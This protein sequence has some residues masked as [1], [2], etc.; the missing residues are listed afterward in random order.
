MRDRFRSRTR[1]RDRFRSQTRWNRLLTRGQPCRHGTALLGLRKHRDELRFFHKL[2]GHTML[3]RASRRR[4][5]HSRTSPVRELSFALLGLHRYLLVNRG[6][7]PPVTKQL[8]IEPR[9]RG[10]RKRPERADL[11]APVLS[12]PLSHPHLPGSSASLLAASARPWYHCALAVAVCL[13][14]SRGLTGTAVGTAGKDLDRGKLSVLRDP[15]A[16]RWR[17]GRPRRPNPPRPS[18]RP[19]PGQ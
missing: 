7:T 18:G 12:Q 6:L 8:T 17:A 5:G 3:R 15:E 10:D 11:R 13:L 16:L 2:R 4:R 9:R 1:M 19:V 14:E